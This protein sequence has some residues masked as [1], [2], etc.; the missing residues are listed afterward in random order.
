MTI[1][2]LLAI[3][4]LNPTE[5]GWHNLHIFLEKLKLKAIGFKIQLIIINDGSIKWYEPEKPLPIPSK[6]VHLPKNLGKGAAI[7]KASDYITSDHNIFSFIDFDC[8]F[9]QSDLIGI[10][11]SIIHGADLCIGDRSSDQFV[12]GRTHRRLSR[13]I[14]HYFFK[15]IIRTIVIGGVRDSQCGIKAFH[16]G[17]AKMISEKS[18]LNGFLFDVEWL[19]IALAHRLCIRYWPV[20][21]SEEHSDTKLRYFL[22]FRMNIDF[23]KIFFSILRRQYRSERLLEWMEYKRGN[24]LNSTT[25]AEDYENNIYKKDKVDLEKAPII[26]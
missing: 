10:W 9:K 17:A 11:K 4:V 1:S 7:K 25:L 15:L 24:I 19:Y 23:V 18:R 3:P 20:E 5:E 16:A 21:V 14:F 13:S 12:Y 8:P 26:I 22:S 6:I 2:V